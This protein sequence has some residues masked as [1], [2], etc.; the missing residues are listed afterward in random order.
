M[1]TRSRVLGPVLLAL[2]LQL[3]ASVGAQQ[4]ADRIYVRRIE[5]L[6]VTRT[7]DEVLRRELRQT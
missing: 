3:T 7:N 1:I 4:S 5:F 2:F 6:G